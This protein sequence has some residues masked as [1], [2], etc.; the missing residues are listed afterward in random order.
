MLQPSDDG[1]QGYEKCPQS[2]S[3][4]C[5]DIHSRV[6]RVS[7]LAVLQKM[8]NGDAHARCATKEQAEVETIIENGSVIDPKGERRYQ[9]MRGCRATSVCNKSGKIFN[10]NPPTS[11]RTKHKVALIF[12]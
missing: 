5:E 7:P 2:E 10:S 9:A 11:K 4:R 12:L 6:E 1:R 3:R 8:V